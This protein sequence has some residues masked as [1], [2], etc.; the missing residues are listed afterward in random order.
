MVSEY[1]VNQMEKNNGII[2]VSNGME[3]LMGIPRER[4]EQGIQ[5]LLEEGFH[6]YYITVKRI[7]T[8]SYELL[9]MP[10]VTKEEAYSRL[11]RKFA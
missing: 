8:I 2:D 7:R 1:L 9:A 5:E 11:M 10:D 6:K 4:L 3:M